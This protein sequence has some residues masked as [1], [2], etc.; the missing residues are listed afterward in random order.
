MP[1]VEFPKRR[2]CQVLEVPDS[3]KSAG[4]RVLLYESVKIAV[5]D[6]KKDS[7]SSLVVV[8]LRSR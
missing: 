5:L 1:T 6:F 3:A 2:P 8:E 4:S 7:Y